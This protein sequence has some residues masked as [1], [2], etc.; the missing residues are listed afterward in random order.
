TAVSTLLAPVM[1]PFLM[2]TF[3]GEFVDIEF[4]AMFLS[5]IKMI[6]IPIAAGLIF[7]YFFHGKVKWLNDFM[8]IISMAG[9]VAIIAVITA[10]G[11]DNLLAIGLL[12]IVAAIIHNA[13]GYAMG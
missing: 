6:I 4:Y 1:T 7:N 3:A 5:I 11:R 10:S 13:A 8:P 12:L 2:Q 9:I